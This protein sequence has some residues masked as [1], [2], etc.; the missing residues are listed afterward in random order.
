[1][2]A[3]CSDVRHIVQS[4]SACK[5]HVV[6][7]NEIHIGFGIC[8]EG[9]VFFFFFSFLIAR[10]GIECLDLS[11]VTRLHTTHILRCLDE[12]TVPTA[13]RR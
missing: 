1:M 5:E 4:K 10:G 8:R 7:R 12:A 13:Y 6:R 2:L 9:Q 3:Q 11:N